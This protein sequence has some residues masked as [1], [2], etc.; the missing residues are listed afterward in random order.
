MYIILTFNQ[1]KVNIMLMG[2]Y[3]EIEAEPQTKYGTQKTVMRWLI[4]E[5]KGAPNFAM[6]VV[7]IEPGGFVGMHEHPY[8]HEVFVLK[9]TGL[10]KTEKESVE[11]RTGDFVFVPE[12]VGLHGF[13][14]TGDDIFEFICCIPN[15]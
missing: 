14:N 10:A 9:G 13:E 5:E 2:H 12:D 7:T 1:C 4:S 6:R 3:T 8:E 11:L 15:T